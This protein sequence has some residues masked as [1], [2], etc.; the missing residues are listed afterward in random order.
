MAIRIPN[1]LSPIPPNG[2]FGYNFADKVEIIAGLTQNSRLNVNRR[3]LIQSSHPNVCLTLALIDGKRESLI[4]S[5]YVGLCDR[6]D[7]NATQF[8]RREQKLQQL[9]T[10][11]VMSRSVANCTVRLQIYLVL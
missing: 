10:P 7:F 9:R 1:D 11:G 3:Y 8:F 2:M 5:M 4:E 6:G